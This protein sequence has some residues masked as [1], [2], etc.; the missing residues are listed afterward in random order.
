MT[1]HNPAVEEIM[2]TYTPVEVK[3]LIDRSTHKEFVH[4]QKPEDIM[5]FYANHDM[6]IH[7]WLLDDV[8]AFQFYIRLQAAYNEAQEGEDEDTLDTA[9]MWHEMGSDHWRQGK[10][11]EAIQFYKKELALRLK[12]EDNHGTNVAATY[13]GMG[14]VYHSQGKYDEALE[15]YNKYMK[16]FLQ[17]RFSFLEHLYKTSMIRINHENNNQQQHHILLLQT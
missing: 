7:H 6:Y 13:N 16:V 8:Y 12:L 10:Y 17:T 4:H 1:H 2:T 15:H 5:K 9:K 14:S 3:K 11:P